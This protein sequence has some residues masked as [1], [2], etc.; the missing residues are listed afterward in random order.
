MGE[1]PTASV[2]LSEYLFPP[3][4]FFEMKRGPG[5]SCMV[6]FTVLCKQLSLV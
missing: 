6:R 2:L 4:F 3:L 1:L 5:V